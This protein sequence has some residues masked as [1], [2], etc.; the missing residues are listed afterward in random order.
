MLNG[1]TG[2]S[3]VASPLLGVT[4]HVMQY[5]CLHLLLRFWAKTF[6]HV[7]RADGL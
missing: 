7:A 3:R 6:K 5:I 1:R 4:N 2:Y